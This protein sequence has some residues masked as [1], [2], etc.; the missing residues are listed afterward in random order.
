M[1][2]RNKVIQLR[3]NINNYFI[4]SY[5]DVC[6]V[7]FK[8]SHEFIRSEINQQ[9]IFA[10]IVLCKK[11]MNFFYVGSVVFRGPIFCHQCFQIPLELILSYRFIIMF[12]DKK[13]IFYYIFDIPNKN[14][15]NSTC[16]IL[17]E[18]IHLASPTTERFYAFWDRANLD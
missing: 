10:L 13:A 4:I 15:E 16:D 17:V 6:S 8:Y 18:N 14:Y 3:H 2:Q 7:I 9:G 1:L 12:I 5:M 11:L